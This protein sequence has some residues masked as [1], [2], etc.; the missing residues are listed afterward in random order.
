MIHIQTQSLFERQTG[1]QHEV[2]IMFGGIN[3]VSRGHYEVLID[4][5]FHSRH[6]RKREAFSEIVN[7]IKCNHWT[8][9]NRIS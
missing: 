8:P 1:K 5:N 7:I 6:Y 2:S 9:V 4:G 3:P